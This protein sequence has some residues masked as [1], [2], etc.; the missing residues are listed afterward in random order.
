MQSPLPPQQRPESLCGS[1]WQDAA[2]RMITGI[3]YMR[4]YM[5]RHILHAGFMCVYHVCLMYVSYSMYDVRMRRCICKCIC[6][7]CNTLNLYSGAACHCA[8]QSWKSNGMKRKLSSYPTDTAWLEVD[9]SRLR[10]DIFVSGSS[11][12][13]TNL[14][15]YRSDLDFGVFWSHQKPAASNSGFYC[16]RGNTWPTDLPSGQSTQAIVE[17]ARWISIGSWYCSDITSIHTR[18]RMRI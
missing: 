12:E 8:G 9:I 13:G 2:K 5:H 10:P 18:Q 3:A 6:D 4:Y 17:E 15:P 14:D 7:M 11:C 16:S 1:P